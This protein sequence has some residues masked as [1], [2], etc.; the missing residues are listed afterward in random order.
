MLNRPVIIVALLALVWGAAA[1]CISSTKTGKTPASDSVQPVDAAVDTQVDAHVPDSGADLGPGPDIALPQDTSPPEDTVVPPPQD[2]TPPAWPEGASLQ[3][4]DITPT[5]LTLSWP[6]AMDDTFVATYAVYRDEVIIENLVGPQTKT[7]ISDLEEAKAVFFKVVATDEAG[8][9][10][11]ALQLTVQTND[12]TPP[13][14]PAGASLSATEVTDTGASLAWTVAHDNVQVMEYRVMEGDTVLQT[15]ADATQ[16]ELSTLTP[17]TEYSLHVVAVDG[18]GNVS[19]PGPSLAFKTP[20]TEAPLWAEG[21]ALNIEVLD[22]TSLKI[23]WLPEVGDAGGLKTYKVFENKVAVGTL[24]VEQ[25]GNDPHVLA[26]GLKAK[27]TYTYTV[28]AIDVAG[29][30]STNGPTATVKMEDQTV[31]SWPEGAD[32]LASN[33]TPN[34]LTLAWTPANDDVSVT[35]YHVHQDGEEI[36]VIATTHAAIQGLGPWTDYTF[37]VWAKDGAGNMSGKG[38]SL[39]LKTPD[40]SHPV[41][42]E[43]GDSFG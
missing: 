16:V 11:P 3:A 27:G 30:I 7:T 43:G 19:K 42:P 31:P 5:S 18:A 13:T 22:A 12:K 29:N 9:T 8:N 34:T 14:W 24:D 28:Q 1:G 41:W 6:S 37:T 2:T 26:K 33:I 25:E 36:A 23:G 38:P 20:D 32:L 39:T 10:S 15:V 40:S 21:S 35:A 17:W 4:S